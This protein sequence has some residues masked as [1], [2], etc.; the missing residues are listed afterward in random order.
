MYAKKGKLHLNGRELVTN[1]GFLH[2]SSH[3]LIVMTRYP[4][5]GKTKTRLIPA[6][7][8]QGATQLHRYLVEYTLGEA[9]RLQAQYPTVVAVYFTGGSEQLMQ[10]WLGTVGKYVPQGSGTLGQRMA[11]AFTQSFDQGFERVV[12]IG[13][14]CLEL[15]AVL[16]AQAFEQLSQRDVVLGPAV[17]GGYYLI[18]LRRWIQALF[19]G[20]E[21]GTDQVFAQTI[22]IAKRLNLTVACLPQLADIDRPEDLDTPLIQGILKQGEE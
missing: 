20:I 18:G 10:Q 17:D 12:M 8:A 7:G 22:A 4:E 14:D 15:K 19:V 1:P 21:W 3:R 2:E 9:Q 16:L 5:P 11:E 6:L 13:S